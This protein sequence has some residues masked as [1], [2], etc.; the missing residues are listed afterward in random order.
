MLAVAVL[1][2]ATTVFAS[3][4]RHCHLL[5]L[6]PGG[7]SSSHSH[8]L[9]KLWGVNGPGAPRLVHAHV[10]VAGGFWRPGRGSLAAGG[11]SRSGQPRQSQADVQLAQC[12]RGD[13]RR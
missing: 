1:C 9:G 5:T 11:R 6:G 2:A 3:V 12:A 10:L 8:H 4:G 13:T 7:W